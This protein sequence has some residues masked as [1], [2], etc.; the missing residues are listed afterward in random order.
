MKSYPF[1]SKKITYDEQGLPVYDRAV[2]S[3]FLRKVFSNYFSDGVFYK[4]AN[5]L[6]VVAD[7]GMQVVVEPG[8]CHIR[9]AMGIE[10]NRRTLVV[11]ASE[12]MDRID[13]VVAR[14]DLSVDVRS[15]DLYVLKGAA[16][17]SPQPPTLTRDSTKWEIGLANLFV[18]KNVSTISQQRITDTRLDPGRCGMVAQTIGELDTAPYF[19]QLAAAIAQHQTDAEAQL[20]AL[21][22]AIE[23]VEG[24]SAWMM[25]ALYDPYNLRAD[26]GV[27]LYTHSKTGT[28]HN[29]VGTG[30]NGRAKIVAAFE[31]GDTVQLNGAPVVATCGAD[32]VDADTFVIGKWVTFVADAEGGQ[33]NFKGGGGLSGSKLAAASADVSD[34]LAGKTFFAGSKEIGTGTMPNRGAW[35]TTYTGLDV[36]IPN[37]CHNGAGK[38]SVD[39]GNKGAW[40]AS[41]DAGASISV[42]K[43]W[44][45]GAGSVS[46]PANFSAGSGNRETTG[47][48]QEMRRDEGNH[49]AYAHTYMKVNV[50]VQGRKV[51]VSGDAHFHVDNNGTSGIV[52][53]G[54]Y[55]SCNLYFE[56]PF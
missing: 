5:A 52:G 12:D 31:K 24:D 48:S 41:V 25:K 8:V 29:F 26:L 7:T 44:H 15:V 42:P 3:A 20:A 2:D 49:L 35:G 50:T 19:A 28:T 13:T 37:G 56:V 30:I 40:S 46:S 11:Q 10:E 18:A 32:P 39:G 36:T 27:Q 55:S 51:I 21:Q 33:I 14:L 45:N 43:G 1:T 38:V 17:E 9:G 4:P 6:Q 47:N 34:V 16:A 23:A 53:T 54:D 22:A